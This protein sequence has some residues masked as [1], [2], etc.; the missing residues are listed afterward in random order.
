MTMAGYELGRKRQV[1]RPAH[2]CWREER[3]SMDCGGKR[4]HGRDAALMQGDFR[5]LGICKRLC[6]VE[7]GV[8]LRLPPHSIKEAP[9]KQ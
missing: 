2:T 6:K 3:F 5:R 7:S 8:A 1:E 9:K 4:E